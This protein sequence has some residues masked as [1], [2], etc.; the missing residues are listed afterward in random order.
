[1][2]SSADRN[3]VQFFFKAFFLASMKKDGGFLKK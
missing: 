3:Q 1:M 2:T